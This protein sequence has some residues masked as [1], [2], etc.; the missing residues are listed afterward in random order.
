MSCIR[1][2]TTTRLY[3]SLLRHRHPLSYGHHCLSLLLADPYYTVSKCNV[4]YIYTCFRTCCRGHQFSNTRPSPSFRDLCV[5]CVLFLVL[6]LVTSLP[7]S[8]PYLDLD[9]VHQRSRLAPIRFPCSILSF[10]CFVFPFECIV[11]LTCL[12]AI[13]INVV[14]TACT[15]AILEEA[16][17]PSRE[18]IAHIYPLIKKTTACNDKSIKICDCASQAALISYFLN[19]KIRF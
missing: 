6:A 11:H 13:N 19:K 5:L 12:Q 17:A 4:Q 16:S 9:L 2:K 7:I 15:C 18:S 3:P 8:P 14:L 10:R 1:G